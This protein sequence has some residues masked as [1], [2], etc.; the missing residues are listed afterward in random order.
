MGWKNLSYWLKGGIIALIIDI[1]LSIV[2]TSSCS[3]FY[4]I[5]P[6]YPTN[7]PLCYYLI[8]NEKI[9]ELSIIILILGILI[10]WLYGRNKK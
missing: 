10:G 8:V 2:I 7:Q 6:D 3:D 5:G 1:F 9:L 4:R